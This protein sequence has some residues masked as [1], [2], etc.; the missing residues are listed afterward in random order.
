MNAAEI[1]R[2]GDTVRAHIVPIVGG[3]LVDVRVL[4]AGG[5]VLIVARV[6]DRSVRPFVLQ[7]VRR[8]FPDTR[9]KFEP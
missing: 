7:I 3:K 6:A 8:Y 9:V 2:L 1:G 5:E 4:D